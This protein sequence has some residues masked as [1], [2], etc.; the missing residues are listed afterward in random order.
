M[1]PIG[2]RE[3]DFELMAGERGGMK[4]LEVPGTGVVT[5]WRYARMAG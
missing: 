1:W 4:A 3:R 5:S 2:G